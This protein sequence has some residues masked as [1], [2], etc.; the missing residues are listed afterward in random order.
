MPITYD[1]TKDYLYKKEGEKRGEMK[2]KIEGKT[3]AQTENILKLHKNAGFT[4][5]QI[6]QY[7]ELPLG[8]VREVIEGNRSY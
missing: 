2:G 7:L 4:A 1:I 8:Q 5:E 3:E 6:A